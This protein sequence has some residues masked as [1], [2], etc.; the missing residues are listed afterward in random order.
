MLDS[1]VG[2][3]VSVILKSQSSI[4]DRLP[5]LQKSAKAVDSDD[6]P[7]VKKKAVATPRKTP[8]KVR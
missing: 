2:Y 7:L 4:A 3:T 1:Y 8:A 5:Y 6:E